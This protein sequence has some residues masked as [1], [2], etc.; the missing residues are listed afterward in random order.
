[1]VG[2]VD[3]PKAPPKITLTPSRFSKKEV[4]A[5]MIR[6]I[7]CGDSETACYMSAELAS[8]E[9][10]VLSDLVDVLIGAM[11]SGLEGCPQQADVWFAAVGAFGRAL[12]LPTTSHD[13][14]YPT[15][16][17]VCV[18]TV[19]AAFAGGR[20]TTI[21]KAMHNLTPHLSSQSQS[22][23]GIIE[24]SVRRM[25]PRASADPCIVSALVDILSACD[26]F[27]RLDRLDR[28]DAG[29]ADQIHMA[30]HRVCSVISDTTVVADVVADGHETATTM[31]IIVSNNNNNNKKK[32]RTKPKPRTDLVWHLWAFC[33]QVGSSSGRAS[34]NSF[35]RAAL[36]IYEHRYRASTRMAR[37]RVLST[38][39]AA[40]AS[41]DRFEPG[42]VDV[43]R[44][45]LHKIL[46]L[47]TANIGIVY[48]EILGEHTNDQV[49]PPLLS[50]P[51]PQTQPSPLPQLLSQQPPQTQPHPQ[52]PL[53]P[54]TQPR[55]HVR[56]HKQAQNQKQ[57]QA[58]AA[59]DH[60]YPDS[61][62]IEHIQQQQQ[63]H[64]TSVPIQEFPPS[65]TKPLVIA[66]K[67]DFLRCYTRFDYALMAAVASDVATLH[68]ENQKERL[69]KHINIADAAMRASI[70]EDRYHYI[71]EKQECS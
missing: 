67:Q 6:S 14:P 1:M 26:R 68:E 36:A 54:Q 29:K 70:G 41:A 64:R 9:G 20:N 49:Q 57:N 55:Q 44:D 18:M 56:Q 40:L 2:D 24:Q 32:S 21:N 16:R 63:R 69:A 7:K 13:D 11:V 62:S 3:G 58:Q 35:L 43:T 33:L 51:P 50:Q 4:Q 60:V 47:A 25:C 22:K 48:S 12:L 71:C 38:A 65:S 39:F 52:Q 28:L 34:L 23:R 19:C 42:S 45:R 37:L 31:A 10:T 8:T 61:Y 27:D 15:R 66:S 30:V 46:E 53:Q 59:R 17:M 5:L